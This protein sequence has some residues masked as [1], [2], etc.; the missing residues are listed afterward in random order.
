[1][2][3][4]KHNFLRWFDNQAE[5]LTPIPHP[6][7]DDDAENPMPILVPGETSY[8]YI[9]TPDFVAIGGTD[10]V[11]VKLYT[12]AGVFVVNVGTANVLTIQNGA[13]F[14]NYGSFTG[15][16]V[17]DGC[18]RLQIGANYSNTVQIISDAEY[19]RLN[20]V[21]VK[22]RN[23]L[24]SHL[25][26][27]YYAF[28]PTFYQQFRLPILDNAE[29]VIFDGEVYRA[30]TTGKERAYS[31]NSKK[32]RT[33]TFAPADK[34]TNEAIETLK[35]HSLIY[36]NGIEHAPNLSNI[37]RLEYDPTLS[38][39]INRIGLVDNSEAELNYCQ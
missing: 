19:I 2:Q 13:K 32:T 18:Y 4:N 35:Q 29:D 21:V 27:V 7:I 36:V 23:N 38:L 25:F 26:G 28:L 5:T 22:F 31:I 39:N 10:P 20:T 30:E 12:L 16:A 8:F 6:L 9:N 15:P 33:L 11:D 3:R 37:G 24:K 34:E 14:H 1:M 17:A